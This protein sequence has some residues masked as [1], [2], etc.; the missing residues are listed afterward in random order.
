MSKESTTHFNL[1]P[2]NLP[3]ISLEEQRRL[4][5][6]SD[7]EIDF[8]DITETDEAFWSGDDL[9]QESKKPVY[10]C[11]DEYIVGWLKTHGKTY[12]SQINGILRHYIESQGT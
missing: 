12:Q 9:I 5:A 10:L 3:E 8:S 2:D 1:N 6:L 7:D 11:L 4:S